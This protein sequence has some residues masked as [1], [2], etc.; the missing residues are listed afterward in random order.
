M[1]TIVGLGN[2]QPGTAT[3]DDDMADSPSYHQ[4]VRENTVQQLNSISPG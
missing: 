1:A 3:F 2:H 4:L